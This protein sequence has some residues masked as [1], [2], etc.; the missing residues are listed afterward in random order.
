MYFLSSSYI[1]MKFDISKK[2]L[3][4]IVSVI[5]GII[6]LR[7][8]IGFA[9]HRNHERRWFEQGFGRNFGNIGC[10]ANFA[11][12]NTIGQN[13]TPNLSGLDTIITTKDY[14][15][16]QTFFSGSRMLQQINTPEKFATRVELQTTMKKAQELQAQLWS[17]NNGNFG[18][19]MYGGQQGRWNRGVSPEKWRQQ[20]R[21]MMRRR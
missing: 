3:I 19:M 14:A 1:N 11:E 20:G 13:Q 8:I 10:T 16:F 7:W 6:V 21:S 9:F 18:P 4:I 5:A 12:W 17:G 15:A 2:K